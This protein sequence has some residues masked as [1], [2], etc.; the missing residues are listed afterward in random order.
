MGSVLSLAALVLGAV[1]L[2]YA[3]R[4]RYTESRDVLW[5]LYVGGLCL[6]LAGCTTLLS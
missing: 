3:F 1:C 4:H 5:L 2:R 6:L